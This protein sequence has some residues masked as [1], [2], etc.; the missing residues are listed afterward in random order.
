MSLKPTELPP[1]PERTQQ[2]A[3]AAFKKNNLYLKMRDTFDTFLKDEHF[4]DL[5]PKRGQPASAPW[6]L[7]LV[8]LFQFVENLSDIQA[9]DAVRSRIDW[10][11]ALS[12]ELEDEGFD[13]S[14]LCEFRT[15][16]IEHQA[17]TRLFEAMLARFG[18]EGMLKQ[19]G[20]QRTDSVGNALTAPMCWPKCAP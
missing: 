5:F 15:R 9:A 16:L 10:K 4:A 3:K 11:Y 6:R 2:V 1:I 12:L 19:R 17:E 7:M 8:T 14:I 13:A 18:E 20:R